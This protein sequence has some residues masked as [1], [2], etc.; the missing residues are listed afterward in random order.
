MKMLFGV[1]S[2]GL[3]HVNRSYLIANEVRKQQ[4]KVRI[5][6]VCGEPAL[7]FFKG[8]EE[9]IL[10]VSNKLK[11]LS[12]FIEKLYVNGRIRYNLIDLLKEIKTIK[13]NYELISQSVDINNY[14]LIVCDE[15]WEILLSD[16]LK[17]KRCKPSVVW[18]TDFVNIP[19]SLT[20]SQFLFTLL[21]NKYLKNRIEMFDSHIFIGHEKD[22]PSKKW[23]ILCGERINDWAKRFFLFTGL[24]PGFDTDN[25][26]GKGE[27]REKLGFESNE[28]VIVATIGGTRI[29]KDL[30]ESVAATYPLLREKYK[31]RIILVCG[32]RLR[33]EE[34]KVNRYVEKFGYVPDLYRLFAA[35]DCVITQAGLGT[36]T[37]LMVLGIP[38]IIIPIEGHYE[39]IERAEKLRDVENMLIIRRKEITIKKLANQI[40]RVLNHPKKLYVKRYFNGAKLAAKTIVNLAASH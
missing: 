29:G 9:R 19:Y 35:S 23:F 6:W 13:R 5:D 36:I 11:S 3:G 24:F 27:L 39:Q 18:I 8:K 28:K 1:S 4:P 10:N 12:E 2:V 16:F 26:P 32:P 14:D 31:V 15:F 21:G 37:E 40:S 38:S 17:C 34:L 20:P 22:L 25:L 33:P 30:L 7:T